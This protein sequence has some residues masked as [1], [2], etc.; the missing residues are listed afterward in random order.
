MQ[1][2]PVTFGLTFNPLFYSRAD[3][4][5]L[6]FYKRRESDLCADIQELPLWDVYTIFT[7]LLLKS[8]FIVAHRTSK[9][10]ATCHCLCLKQQKY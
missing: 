7:R 8:A 6:L 2:S 1:V 10:I 4:E 3:L 9:K 5:K